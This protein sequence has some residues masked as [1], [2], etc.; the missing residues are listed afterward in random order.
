MT[1]TSV[2]N[3]YSIGIHTMTQSPALVPPAEMGPDYKSS[4][5]A[6]AAGST[7]R[8]WDAS[9]ASEDVVS[10][11]SVM[12]KA[13]VSP[14]A[15]SWNRNN[16]V[17]A[18]GLE[19]GRVQIRYANGT[20]MST[21]QDDHRDERGASP[22]TSLSW[23][24]G[25]KTLAVGSQG[26]RVSVHDMTTKQHTS[27][28]I[29]HDETVGGWSGKLKAV[30]LRHHPDDAFLAVGGK[31]SV[32]LYSLRLEEAK[33]S[34]ACSASSV[35]KNDASFSSVSVAT[36][37]PYL[38]AGSDKNGIV[39]VWDYVTEA[40]LA[41]D[42]FRH[43]HKGSTKVE[44]A[45][46]TP[47]LLYSV[48]MDGILKMQDLRLPSSIA[49]PTAMAS[50][51]SA[52]GISSLSVHEFSGDIAVGTNDGY[53][54]IFTA[55]LASRQPKHSLFFGDDVRDE[56]CPVLAVDWA[57]SYHNVTLH[58]RQ[59]VLD[60]ER[61]KTPLSRGYHEHQP[62]GSAGN[63]GERKTERATETENVPH[64]SATATARGSP[65]MRQP[66]PPASA[67]PAS[68][69]DV[70]SVHL[71]PSGDPWKIRAANVVDGSS[72]TPSSISGVPMASRREGSPAMAASVKKTAIQMQ[73]ASELAAPE[74]VGGGCVDQIAPSTGEDLSQMLLALHLDMVQMHEAQ[75]AEIR[76][77][78]DEVKQLKEELSFIRQ[79]AKPSGEVWGI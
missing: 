16:K 12:A 11:S 56:E 26:G 31:D 65:A 27:K 25:S 39:A 62:A 55:G 46:L 33:G 14:T 72:T 67:S 79:S 53:V 4:A 2:D 34:C 74:G 1:T 66:S 5:L 42:K 38:A 58:A 8:V 71:M 18:I 44:L 69:G 41:C 54:Y 23:S 19:N 73:M 13:A 76:G 17:A 77:L 9:L 15:I 3:L 43:A 49:S 36:G 29:R 63:V 37:K 68:D 45:P 48:G 28:V 6:V 21:L 10:S 32:E 30:G 57:R 47:S 78:R 50:V 64:L 35:V 7:V 40:E 24:T 59:A 52:A 51:P 22:V 60:A 61:V 20:C 70:P 75:S